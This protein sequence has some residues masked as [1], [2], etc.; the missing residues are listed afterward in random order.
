LRV[1][2]SGTALATPMTCAAG[3]QPLDW[4]ARY[5]D[6][7]LFE[8]QTHALWRRMTSVASQV[9]AT[10][11]MDVQLC[12][13]WSSVRATPGTAGLGMQRQGST[14][15]RT[16]RFSWRQRL[17]AA[18][19]ALEAYPLGVR[20]VSGGHSVST[21]RTPS[22]RHREGGLGPDP[23]SGTTTKTWSCVITPV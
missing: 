6:E 9:S 21:L 22:R 10:A 4:G 20:S 15:S 19:P 1:G 17:R 11:R 3:G 13:P 7:Q 18:P 23:R 5:P 16:A 2:D 14:K 12:S 8:R